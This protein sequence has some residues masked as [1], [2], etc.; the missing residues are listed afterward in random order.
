MHFISKDFLLKVRCERVHFLFSY[1]CRF[2]FSESTRLSSVGGEKALAAMV[3]SLSESVEQEFGYLSSRLFQ[4]FK[5]ASNSMYNLSPF[6]MSLALLNM[7]VSSLEITQI[8]WLENRS[9]CA[10]LIIAPL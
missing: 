10:I 7:N 2:L 4:I 6:F 1:L 8:N 5:P 9:K 3:A